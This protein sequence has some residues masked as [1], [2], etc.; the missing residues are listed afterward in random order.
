[1]NKKYKK[2]KLF[3]IIGSNS[4]S[5]GSFINELLNRNYNVIGVSRSPEKK[6]LNPYLKNENIKNFKFYRIDLNKNL[7]KINNLINSY[8]PK[9]IINF[10]AQ[11]MVNESWIYPEDWYQTNLVSM[12]KL[13]KSISKLKFIKIFLNFSTPEVYG[14]ISKLTDEKAFFNPTTPYAISRSAF[15]FHLLNLNK[16][17][18]FPV[19]I[20]RT[21]NVYGPYQDLYRVIPKTILSIM[22]NKDIIIHGKG[23]SVRSFIHI[24]DVNK[25]LLRILNTKNIGKSFHISTDKFISIKQLC[26]KIREKM[27]SV[28]KLKYISDRTGKDFAYKLAS[29]K[30]KKIGWKSNISINEGLNETIEWYTKNIHKL[31]K[32]NKK[33]IHKK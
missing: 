30:I 3:M 17:Y 6:E 9:Y 12:T 21:A 4:F 22:N 8:K 19:I 14:N 5:G 25:A 1:M 16:F 23:K 18:K 32:L 10:A 27:N 31:N 20:T 15:D 24:Q 13:V 29:D 33:Y 7:K 11:G 28:V 2:K 26:E